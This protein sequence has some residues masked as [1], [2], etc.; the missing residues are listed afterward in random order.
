[1]RK[2]FFIGHDWI[3]SNASKFGNSTFILQY[4]YWT[5]IRRFSRKR[6]GDY[7]QGTLDRPCTKKNGLVE[8]IKIAFSRIFAFQ[9]CV[10]LF[11]FHITLLIFLLTFKQ[12]FSRFESVSINTT[13]F[14]RRSD[15]LQ[16]QE[17]GLKSKRKG[18]VWYTR[19]LCYAGFSVWFKHEVRVAMPIGSDI[20]T[21]H[22]VRDSLGWYS[23]IVR[24]RRRIGFLNLE[25]ANTRN[26]QPERIG[27]CHWHWETW[28]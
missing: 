5:Q 18:R 6:A 27:T 23:L 8:W 19:L 25:F 13:F 16:V 12:V 17:G 21:I 26:Q 20:V 9:K 11:I 24:Y 7:L 28:R 15:P 2:L 14:L 1:M 10:P 4:C 3:W 22:D